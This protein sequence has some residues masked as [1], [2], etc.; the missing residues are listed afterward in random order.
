MGGVSLELQIQPPDRYSNVLLFLVDT[1]WS[2]ILVA[3]GTA[4]MS[5]FKGRTAIVTGGGGGIGSA[6]AGHWPR[7][8]RL[9]PS[10]TVMG[11]QPDRCRVDR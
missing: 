10:S 6:T 4:P 8:A 11:R 1:V 3:I 7:V 2:S 9:S 5:D